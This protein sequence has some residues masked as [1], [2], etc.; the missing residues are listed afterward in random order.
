LVVFV[1]AAVFLLL[2]YG[3]I[4]GIILAFLAK[5]RVRSKNLMWFEVQEEIGAELKARRLIAEVRREA[6]GKRQDTE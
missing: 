1:T 3:V 4:P 5:G 6:A 2:A